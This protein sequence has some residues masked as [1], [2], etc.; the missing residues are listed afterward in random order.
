[1][2]N[3]SLHQ[4]QALRTAFPE[5]SSILKT[6]IRGKINSHGAPE[7]THAS[8][9]G[10]CLSRSEPKK[11]KSTERVPGPVKFDSDNNSQA[12]VSRVTEPQSRL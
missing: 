3:R 7:H 12:H 1:M 6:T 9:C 8:R 5:N 11:L 2:L 10:S 4:H